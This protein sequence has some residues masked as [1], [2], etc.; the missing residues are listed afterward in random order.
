MFGSFFK[1]KTVSPELTTEEAIKFLELDKKGITEENLLEL[2]F[3]GDVNLYAL[4]VLGI[5]K[6]D[7]LEFLA[8][9]N[10]TLSEK[11]EDIT[12][13]SNNS[14]ISFCRVVFQHFLA[15]G[16]KDVLE[17]L[18]INDWKKEQDSFFEKKIE[19]LC[20]KEHKSLIDIYDMFI[21]TYKL[22]YVKVNGPKMSMR[23]ADAI[24]YLESI[25][26]IVPQIE[27]PLT[28]SEIVD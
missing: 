12:D 13:K 11:L 14:F 25:K 28:E 26:D 21:N 23:K 10:K 7:Y 2:S 24:A 1:N 6:E 5:K 17:G 20:K 19:E 3:I 8:Y 15:S 27:T 9:K 18:S 4:H 22:Y 16:E